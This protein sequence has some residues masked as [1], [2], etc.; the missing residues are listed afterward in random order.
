MNL[1]DPNLFR[2]LCYV[3]GEWRKA[4]SGQTIDVTNPATDE[5]LGTVPKFLGAETH[6]AIAAAKRAQPEW[7]AK[8]AGE[9]AHD[10]APLERSHAR[11]CRRSRADHDARAGKAARRIQRRGRLFR[12]L[13][14]MVRGRGKAHLWRRDPEPRG[15][16]AHRRAEAAGRRRL[17]DH[18]VEFS[19]RDDRAQGGARARRRMHLRVQARDADALS[20]RWR[21]PNSRIARGFPKACSTCSP[22]R[23]ARSA[24]R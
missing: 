16:Q 19:E 5:V 23:R 13:H 21:W 11:A 6:A 10:P 1:K 20:P 8:T 14:R 7:A 22:A 18:A 12:L 2:Q 9:R 4:D 15:R 24:R 3:D 17:R